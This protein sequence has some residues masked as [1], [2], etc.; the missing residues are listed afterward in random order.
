LKIAKKLHKN[1]VERLY[2]GHLEKN[3]KNAIMHK[4]QLWEKDNT[5]SPQINNQSRSLTRTVE[6]LYNWNEQKQGKLHYMKKIY[7][8]GGK[9]VEM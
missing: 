7:Q 3:N 8:S 2:K 9:K 1:P 6:D 4:L 5:F